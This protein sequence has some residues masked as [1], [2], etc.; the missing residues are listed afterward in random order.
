M[1]GREGWDGRTEGGQTKCHTPI[2]ADATHVHTAAL[3]SGTVEGRSGV[4]WH[5]R[6]FGSLGAA[7]ILGVAASEASI[8]NLVTHHYRTCNL[9]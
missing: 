7:A 1:S 9:L 5:C 6:S 3:S 4:A 2:D 8:R